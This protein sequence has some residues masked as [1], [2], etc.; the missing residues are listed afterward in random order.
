MNTTDYLLHQIP[1]KFLK[2]E[3]PFFTKRRT[4]L[5]IYVRPREPWSSRDM[6]FKDSGRQLAAAIERCDAPSMHETVLVLRHV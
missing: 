3:R 6:N 5:E 2:K 1:K 4:R